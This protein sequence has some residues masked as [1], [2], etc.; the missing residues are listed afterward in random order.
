[1]RQGNFHNFLRKYYT[2]GKL[3]YNWPMSVHAS[4]AVSTS[5]VPTCLSF[6]SVTKLIESFMKI[7]SFFVQV[8][9]PLNFGSHTDQRHV[10][11]FHFYENLV[12]ANLGKHLSL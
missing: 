11:H 8:K 6:I 10:S 9:S 4:Q 1:V 7:L 2:I 12:A 3:H 5:S